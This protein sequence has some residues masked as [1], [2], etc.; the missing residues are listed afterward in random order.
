MCV[1]DGGVLTYRTVAAVSRECLRSLNRTVFVGPLS[2]VSH[3]G[4]IGGTQLAPRLCSMTVRT[5]G[6]RALKN[7]YGNLA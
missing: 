1:V 6:L 3:S 5:I 7:T 2:Y 4:D